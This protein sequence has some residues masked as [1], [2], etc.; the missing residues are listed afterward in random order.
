MIL[1]AENRGAFIVGLLIIMMTVIAEKL[2]NSNG[3]KFDKKSVKYA[4][5]QT[6]NNK[7][8]MTKKKSEKELSVKIVDLLTADMD[9]ICKIKGI[10]PSLA[11]NL[12]E[13]LRKKEIQNYQDMLK[14]KGIGASK[15]NNIVK[16]TWLPPQTGLIQTA[17]AYRVKNNISGTF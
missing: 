15:L 3:K 6:A 4:Q 1:D 9:E 14:V 7:N 17:R 5:N 10:G 2:P 12:S 8:D 16:S 11:K 13:A